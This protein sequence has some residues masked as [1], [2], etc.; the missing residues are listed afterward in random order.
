MVIWL[1]SFY[2]NESVAKYLEYMAYL[3]TVSFSLLSGCGITKSITDKRSKY[4]NIT[5]N[6]GLYKKAIPEYVNKPSNPFDFNTY[7]WKD[8]KVKRTIS[9]LVQALSVTA[10]NLSARKIL[11]GT[12]S[13]RNRDEMIYF[14]AYAS[15]AQLNFM[16]D[17]LTNDNLLYSCK[18]KTDALGNDILEMDEMS[19]NMLSQ[20]YAC[21]AAA[22]TQ[23]LINRTKYYLK[24]SS[25]SKKA[26]DSLLPDLCHIAM[27]DSLYTS[28]RILCQLCDSLINIYEY[29]SFS[30]ALIYNTVNVL[31]QELCE[32]ITSKGEIMRIPNDTKISS[33]FTLLLSLSTLSRLYLLFGFPNYLSCS[34]T[35]FMAIKE[36]WNEEEGIFLKTENNNMKYSIKD[37]SAIFSSLSNFRKCADSS[38]IY[39]IDRMISSSF[40]NMILKS[41]IF[42]N[43][44]YPILDEEIINLPKTINTSKKAPPVFLERIEYKIDKS[45]FKIIDDYF[46]AEYSLWSCRLLL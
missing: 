1:E 31:G 20:Y 9:P 30:K 14:L 34:N 29:T 23:D 15:V 42:I 22:L 8:K 33:F 44:S 2:D 32:R 24:L 21:E 19:L 39:D 12:L 10:M 38:A 18:H 16:Y 7:V 5:I 26:L 17:N 41:G 3:N 46:N 35:L 25:N 43:Q 6:I 36:Y 13:I 4:S 11:N 45:K 37:I 40:R 28:S 27:K